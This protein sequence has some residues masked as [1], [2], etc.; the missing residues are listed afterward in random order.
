MICSLLLLAWGLYTVFEPDIEMKIVSDKQKTEVKNV[1]RYRLQYYEEPQPAES[2]E[3]PA[4]NA[5]PSEPEIFPELWSA[6]QQ[7]NDGLR[8]NG[9]SSTDHPWNYSDQVIIPREFGWEQDALGVMKIPKLDFEYPFYLGATDYHMYLG[10][11][12]MSGT[13]MPIGGESTNSVFAVHRQY[14][15]EVE[16][17]QKGDMIIL[18][19]PWDD[20]QY[21]VCETKIIKPSDISNILIRD[22]RDLITLSTCHPWRSGGKY[23]YLVI[24]ERK[25]GTGMDVDEPAETEMIRSSEIVEQPEI[26]AEI[27][28][29]VAA[30]TTQRNRTICRIL[31]CIAAAVVIVLAVVFIKD[32]TDRKRREKDEH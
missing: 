24:A 25:T 27:S 26:S 9:Q 30:E 13:S 31:S 16:K 12:Q 5:E 2:I 21:T 11:A 1:R 14:I 6:M 3:P 20:L 19:T 17:L 7:Y 15:M 8:K 23:R 32:K 29:E 10:A 18:E 28:R 22:G 4:G